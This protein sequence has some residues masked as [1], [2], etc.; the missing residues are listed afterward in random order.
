MQTLMLRGSP[1]LE[2]QLKQ[3]CNETLRAD[4]GTLPDCVILSSTCLGKLYSGN[5]RPTIINN[6]RLGFF[7]VD[8]FLTQRGQLGISV[9]HDCIETVRDVFVP[10]NLDTEKVQIR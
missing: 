5:S 3:R 4:F 7:K 1:V 2:R 10:A 9:E 8:L 6:I